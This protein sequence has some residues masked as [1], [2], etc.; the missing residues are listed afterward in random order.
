MKNP[1]R[2]ILYKYSIPI[3]LLLVITRIF[4]CFVRMFFLLSLFRNLYR[5]L[6]N[7]CLYTFFVDVIPV[8]VYFAE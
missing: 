2:N 7:V 5:K 8:Y 3:L 6:L 4:F 1:Y